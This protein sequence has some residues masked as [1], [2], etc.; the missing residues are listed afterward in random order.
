MSYGSLSHIGGETK[1]KWVYK[2]EWIIGLQASMCGFT[3]TPTRAQGGCKSWISKAKSDELM[4]GR[5]LRTRMPLRKL[6]LGRPSFLLN[7][8]VLVPEFIFVTDALTVIYYEINL[9]N[10][11]L[12]STV[13]TRSV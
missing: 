1:L 11:V 3:P 7:L 10:Y 8:T 12:I 9:F 2:L 4:C 13:I 6:V 5:D